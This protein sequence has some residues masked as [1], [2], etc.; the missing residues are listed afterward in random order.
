MVMDMS[1]LEDR[2]VYH[3]PNANQQRQYEKVRG[4]AWAFAKL[5]SAVV[6]AGREKALAFTHLEQAMMWANAGIARHPD[7][8]SEPSPSA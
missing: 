3:P 1:D 6:P 8:A 5:L 2:F 4:M 7:G